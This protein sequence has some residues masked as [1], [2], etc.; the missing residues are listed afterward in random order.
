MPVLK[1]RP[2]T[3]YLRD[4]TL[5]KSLMRIG[6]V[7]LEDLQLMEALSMDCYGSVR[8]VYIVCK[9]DR[10]L[11]EEFQRWMVSN[12]PVDEVKEIDGAD[13]MAMLSAP[14]DIVQC[15]VDIVAKYN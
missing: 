10:T 7:F 13:H 1:L 11:S 3:T 14:D 15:I 5:A 9:Q 4:I 2:L 8:K 12:N 6:S